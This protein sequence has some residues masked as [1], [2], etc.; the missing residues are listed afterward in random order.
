MCLRGSSGG[1]AGHVWDAG[2]LRVAGKILME[3]VRGER[4]DAG[5]DRGVGA[6]MRKMMTY[7][8]KT[9]RYSFSASMTSDARGRF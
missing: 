4:V 8:W 7:E 3:H 9:R 1:R 6:T 2:R 5:V